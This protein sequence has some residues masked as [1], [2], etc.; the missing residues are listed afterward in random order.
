MQLCAVAYCHF[1]NYAHSLRICLSC[2]TIHSS[3]VAQ[4]RG[5]KRRLLAVKLIIVNIA[6]VNDTREVHLESFNKNFCSIKKNI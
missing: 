4:V 3:V 6:K 1:N 5:G 2:F